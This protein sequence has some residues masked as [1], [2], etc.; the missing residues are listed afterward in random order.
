MNSPPGWWWLGGVCG[1][2]RGGRGV[3]GSRRREHD[4][5][6]RLD[7]VALMVEDGPGTQIGLG[8]PEG[9]FHLPQGVAGADHGLSPAARQRLSALE[10]PGN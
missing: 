9:P 1:C 4:Y 3:C 6:V 8:H 2:R 5:Q 7:G 10:H